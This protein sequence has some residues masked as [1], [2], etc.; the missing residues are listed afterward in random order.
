MWPDGQKSDYFGFLGCR[1][2]PTDSLVQGSYISSNEK[3][4]L[5]ELDE[6]TRAIATIC[7]SESLSDCENAVRALSEAWLNSNRDGVIGSSLSQASVIQGIMEVLFV[8]KDDE[9]LEL[10]ISILAE[11]STKNEINRRCVLNSDP[12][13]DVSIRLLRSSSL[14]LK[15][16]TLLY[17]VKPEAKQMVSM[18]WVPLVLRVLEFGDQSQTLFTVRCAPH[19]AAYYFLDQ[20]LTGFDEDKN[21]ENARQ[22]ISLGGLGLLVRRMEVGDTVEKNRAVSILYYCILA[23]GSCRHYLARNV[24][25]STLI[26]LLVLG[27]QTRI[28][29]ALLT[30]LLLLSR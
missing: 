9:I 8:S 4:H 25:T 20:L 24:K 1:S 16:A 19:E 13:L 6:I 26:S 15:A 11:L 17:L 10:A 2:E 30:E 5:F 14:F 3:S 7:S 21:V 12:Q 28:A 27:K 23:D 29:L 18:E 22:I